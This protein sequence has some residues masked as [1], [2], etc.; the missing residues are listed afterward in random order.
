M[1]PQ[2]ESKWAT[3]FE[4]H[5]FL[6]GTAMGGGGVVLMDGLLGICSSN[7]WSLHSFSALPVALQKDYIYIY[8][9]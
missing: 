5:L 2:E 8:I 7:H 3:S 1:E 6:Y 4:F 9:Y